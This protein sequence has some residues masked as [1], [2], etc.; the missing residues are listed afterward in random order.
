MLVDVTA[1]TNPWES[2]SPLH[3]ELRVELPGVYIPTVLSSALIPPFLYVLCSLTQFVVLNWMFSD[4]FTIRNQFTQ[5]PRTLRRRFMLF[6]L[7]NVILMPFILPFMAIYFAFKVPRPRSY[8]PVTVLF[9][10]TLAPVS[11][12]YDLLIHLYLS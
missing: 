6:G 3:E 5:D 1:V 4:K 9:C 11:V 8:R 2:H 10:V 12:S 7:L